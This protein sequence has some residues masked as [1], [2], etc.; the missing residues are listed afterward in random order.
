MR[1]YTMLCLLV[2]GILA[3]D[4]YGQKETKLQADYAYQKMGYSSSADLY[5]QVGASRLNTAAKARLG[6]SYRL[7]GNTEAAEYWYAIAVAET[8]DAE[9]ILHYAQMLQSNGKCE[10]AITYYNEYLEVVETETI[11]PRANIKDC[12][13]LDFRAKSNTRVT[14]MTALNSPHLDFS[15]IP[16]KGGVVFTS[17]RGRDNTKMIDQWTNDNFSDLFYA[18]KDG[19]GQ[20]KK[21][22]VF[23]GR[24]N[25]QFHDGTA[26]FNKSGTRMFFSRNSEG[27]NSKEVND[28]KIYS[29]DLVDGVWTNIKALPFNDKE[30]ATCHPTLSPN[31][32]YLYFASNRPGGIGGMDLYVVNKRGTNWST[33]RN[34]G[35][36]VNTPSNEIFPFTNKKDEL[37][38]ASNGHQGMGGLDIYS[39]EKANGDW[40]PVENLGA[41]FNSIKDDFG[42][43]QMNSGKE[44]YFSSSR[45]NGLGGDDIYQWQSDEL[46]SS[47]M[48]NTNIIAVIDEATG[49]RI[50]AA[51]V[52]ITEGIANKMTDTGKENTED[53]SDMISFLTDNKGMVSPS[54]A[55]G[56]TYTISVNKP[57]YTTYR[58]IVTAY[59]LL[60]AREWTVAIA[61][62]DGVVLDG[63]VLN[64]K[65]DHAVPNAIVTLF[66]FCTGEKEKVLSDSDG[67][68]SFFL[69]CKC[70]YEIVGEKERFNADKKT[71]STIDINCEDTH[72]ITT[73]LLLNIGSA[74]RTTTSSRS[75]P[76]TSSSPTRI[77]NAPV[78]TS[79]PTRVVNAP[80]ATPVNAPVNRTT[81]VS[82]RTNSATPVVK[83]LSDLSSENLDLSV[84]NIITLDNL[85]YD[86]D[87]FFIRPDAAKELDRIVTLMKQYSTIELELSSHTD[88]RGRKGYNQTLSQKRADVAINYIISK[89][90]SRKRLIARGL[91]EEQLRNHCADETYC[92][93][94]EHQEN[95][96]TEVRVLKR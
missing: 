2:L 72:P 24:I 45:G 4:G 83:N 41:P 88:S 23:E 85:Y 57:G 53:V 66:N 6:D 15:P 26:T 77:V 5:E 25:E 73:T 54:F 69:D 92:S 3:T 30:F 86:Y 32:R 76:I 9:D 74:P 67:K 49:A 94:E 33:P 84:G 14:N 44:G 48:D 19:N 80:V 22:A 39:V 29:A 37:F 64:K 7:N 96:R 90:I 56:Q 82:T 35:P 12:S 52:T 40:L 46:I 16:Y 31:G 38:F 61:K 79:S 21:P 65:Y 51:M 8:P 28:L 68:F 43:S 55:A 18:E 81:P 87:K 36:T 58:K 91:G 11:T 93:E 63:S 13:E 47:T 59:D 42:F 34:L 17:T 50:P 78:A 60:K 70:D 10:E 71:I 62:R 75:V 95:R 27:K 89:G 1:K 20:F